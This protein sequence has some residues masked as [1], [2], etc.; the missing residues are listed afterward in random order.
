MATCIYTTPSCPLAGGGAVRDALLRAQ[1]VWFP[2]RS[3][4]DQQ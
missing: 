2:D 4:W 3:G 1:T